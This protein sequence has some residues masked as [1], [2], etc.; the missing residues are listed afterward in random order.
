MQCSV[1]SNDVSHA[2]PWEQHL[3]AL[4]CTA[5]LRI[6]SCPASGMMIWWLLRLTVKQLMNVPAVRLGLGGKVFRTLHD[7]SWL[8]YVL[9]WLMLSWCCW[10]HHVHCRLLCFATRSLQQNGW[11]RGE[12]PLLIEHCPADSCAGSHPAD[13][14]HFAGITHPAVYQ[15][16]QRLV[17][18]ATL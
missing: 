2:G 17:A 8:F 16:E 4:C 11:R 13:L 1:R 5:K 12:G 7:S 15:S 14:L 6:C 9:S 18:H 3:Q 10:G